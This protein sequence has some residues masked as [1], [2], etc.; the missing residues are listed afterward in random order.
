T[1]A[2]AAAMLVSSSCAGWAET[3]DSTLWVTDG[4]VSSV[5]R[6]GG[7]I[8][9]G[10]SFRYVG[11]PTGGWVLLDAHSGAVRR[12]YPRV[13]GEVLAAAPDG[14]GGW[15]L[16]GTFTRVGDRPRGRLA[17]LDVGGNLTAWDPGAD[18][19][20]YS[21]A[22]SGGTVYAGGG[23]TSIGGQTRKHVAALDA[24]TG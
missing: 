22:V 24:A 11:P 2:W 18:S 4:I 14:S 19:P 9:I 7:T 8:F 1:L 23:F 20:V 5:A 13:E 10:G 15:Y 16:G 21:L 6:D 12:P 17:H 3:V